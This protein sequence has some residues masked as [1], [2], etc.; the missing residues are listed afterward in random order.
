MCKHNKVFAMC[1]VGRNF[2]SQ[3]VL[4]RRRVEYKSRD[5]NVFHAARIT[6][7][8][9]LTLSVRPPDCART[10]NPLCSGYRVVCF[11]ADQLVHGDSVL[12]GCTSTP[13]RRDDLCLAG[14]PFI[15]V[16]SPTAIHLFTRG[17]LNTAIGSSDDHRLSRRG[18]CAKGD[19]FPLQR[20]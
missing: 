5:Q 6:R 10:A 15:A 13:T 7:G 20:R 12:R 11:K 4:G 1:W 19:S 17:Q 16:V 3:P 9:S 8:C 18:H 14:I 2:F